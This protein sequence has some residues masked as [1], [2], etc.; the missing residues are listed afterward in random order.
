V[1]FGTTSLTTGVKRA[2]V[3]KEKKETNEK[4]RNKKWD[5][6]QPVRA[7]EKEVQTVSPSTSYFK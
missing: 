3:H 4:R 1:F 7:K 5:A 2:V 6:K